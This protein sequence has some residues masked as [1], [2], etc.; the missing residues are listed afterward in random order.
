MLPELRR[1]LLVLLCALAL[2][3]SGLAAAAPSAPEPTAATAELQLAEARA[4]A[5]DLLPYAG[6]LAAPADTAIE[7]LRRPEVARRF[8]PSSQFGRPSDADSL[9]L[10]LRLRP[11]ESPRERWL[12]HITNA[13]LAG[14][15][16][17]VYFQEAR[18]WQ[19]QSI[20]RTTPLAQRQIPDA[21]ALF[22]L[23]RMLQES[24]E[25]YLHF[26]RRVVSNFYIYQPE[27]IVA[28]TYQYLYFTKNIRVVF[29]GF[30]FGICTIIMLY[31]MV[32]YFSTRDPSAAWFSASMLGFVLYF[33]SREGIGF[34]IFWGQ[35]P[36]I[37]PGLLLAPL[38]GA[39]SS[40]SISRFTVNF[41]NIR[42]R[43]HWSSIITSLFTA[44][45]LINSVIYAISLYSNTSITYGPYNVSAIGVSLTLVTLVCSRLR[46]GD[47]AI[48]WV[49]AGF[50]LAALGVVLQTLLLTSTLSPKIWNRHAMPVGLVLQVTLL[51]VALAYRMRSVQRTLVEREKSEKLLLAMLPAPIAQRLKAGESPI[52]DRHAEVT[53]LFADIAGFTPLSSE[54]PPERLVQA[55]NTLF[56]R[57]DA[58][59]GERGLEKIKT[60][61]DCYMVVGG[62]PSPRPDHAEA[63][64]E[65]ALA[66]LATVAEPQAAADPALRS[67]RIRI[68]IHCGSAVA[69][70]IGTHKPAYDL[71]G[72]TVNTASRM[73]SHGEPGRIHCTQAVYDKLHPTFEFSERRELEVRGKG[74]MPTYFLLRR[75]AP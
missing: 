71:W 73:E 68:G 59:T 22:E 67:I 15:T 56:S 11:A 13:L 38:G 24:H 42:G 52:A 37:E 47:P 75:R 9:W 31:G 8:L 23:G 66:L 32:L 61:G 48:K 18:S 1:R 28:E 54:L 3:V 50:V 33:M 45:M 7:E 17:T 64:A 53:V 62:L 5:H 40:L 55:L 25:L 4:S 43:R 34:E 44:I 30:I 35:P 60:I 69:G 74:R 16:V 49:L 57:F 14:W 6:L 51:A 65:L 29:Y 72:D 2:H 63:V 36:W 12:L 26:S 70:V 39:I 21:A 46:S 58:L 19:H 20:Q 10:R 27:Q 41:L